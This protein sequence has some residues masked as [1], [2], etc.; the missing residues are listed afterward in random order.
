M[1]DGIDINFTVTGQ[2]ALV[3]ALEAE[4]EASDKAA[5]ALE[6][7]A[8]A[9]KAATAA[10]QSL[11]RSQNQSVRAS[12]GSS[13][14]VAAGNL[15]G[16]RS[17]GSSA[18]G[19]SA[20]S[21]QNAAPSGRRSDLAAVSNFNQRRNTGQGAGHHGAEEESSAI[22]GI[23]QAIV[24]NE[25]QL[26]G[27]N[28]PPFEK[29]LDSLIRSTRLNGGAGGLSPLGG[30]AADLAG[31]SEAGGPIGIA[32]AAAAKAAEMFAQAVSAAADN[33]AKFGQTQ[34]A[35][36]SSGQTTGALGNLG[37]SAD[38]ASAFNDSI[39]HDPIAGGFAALHGISNAPGPYGN[40]DF[41][42][43]IVK[44]LTSLHGMADQGEALRDARA[45]H[46]EE[47]Y[48]RLK[49]LGD[50]AFNNRVGMDADTQA[51]LYGPQTAQGGAEFQ[52]SQDRIG[53]SFSNLG[54]KISRPFM[55]AF[56]R[57][58]NEYADL[59]NGKMTLKRFA[60]GEG[61]DQYGNMTDP[62]AKAMDGLTKATNNLAGKMGI[63]QKQ[64]GHG[65]RTDRAIPA[66]LGMG[67]GYQ[68]RRNLQ[69]HAMRLGAFG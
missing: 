6:R 54:T 24:R 3:K 16:S 35:S 53:Q 9:A 20:S 67:N 47:P 59:F 17:A 25:K 11:S 64:Y 38:Q 18:S 4:A 26:A 58:N 13:A 22:N 30:Q 34:A 23:G 56:T 48:S 66:A 5:S 33:A 36:G 50:T 7:Q 42:Q 14:S 19:G 49:N 32:L 57:T 68:L 60:T 52:N 2:D 29:R 62:H 21:V 8:R 31:L 69:A 10:Y 12:G 46:L 44:A 39:T 63:M 55:D 37:I 15:S 65:E 61:E 27:K 51:K 28:P 40:Q 45:M 1:P 43:E 41:G